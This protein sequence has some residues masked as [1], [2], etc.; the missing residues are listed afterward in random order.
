MTEISE[1]DSSKQVD[2][3]CVS[4]DTSA[5]QPNL[6]QVN[7]IGCAD[8]GLWIFSLEDKKRLYTVN[9]EDQSCSN[10]TENWKTEEH[11]LMIDSGCFGPVCPP[12]FAPQFPMVS[13]TKVEAA[14]AKNVALEHYGQNVVYGHVMT[15]SGKRFLIQI[16]FD[17]M[18]V[19]KPLVSISALKHR[20][21]TIIFN[22]DYDRT[23]FRN[24]TANLVSHDCHSYLHV[25]L[26]NGLPHRKEMVMVG[27]N[28]SND[29]DEEVYGNMEPR[30]MKLKKLR[31]SPMRIKPDNL[32]FLVKRKLQEY[33]VLLNR[34]QM[35]LEWNTT[36][37]MFHSEIGAQ[38][39]LRVVDEF[40]RTDELW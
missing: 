7:T 36:R 28:V 18:N 21:V 14:A 1:S 10:P 6:S 33:Y 8:E 30:E 26:K 22:H 20:G 38:S 11:E 19:R 15:N 23:I 39:V 16:T 29:V 32:I 12:W 24:E 4:S 5:Q 35:L 9:W 40:L 2:D 17:V 31:Q 3:W 27:E 13:S 25:T 34:R 37:H